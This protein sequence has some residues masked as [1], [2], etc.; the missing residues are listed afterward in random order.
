V[1]KR[2]LSI[3]YPAQQKEEWRKKMPKIQNSEY[4]ATKGMK[5]TKL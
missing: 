3:E 1:K 5:I 2:R 4:F